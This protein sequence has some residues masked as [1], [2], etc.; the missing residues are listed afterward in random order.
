MAVLGAVYGAF[1]P[2]DGACVG[3]PFTLGTEVV[4]RFM[5]NPAEDHARIIVGHVSGSDY[6]CLTPDQDLWIESLVADL[7]DIFGVYVRPADRTMPFMLPADGTYL[8]DF[9]AAP[10]AA[11]W[12]GLLFMGQTAANAERVVRGLVAAPVVPGAP[13]VPPLPPPAGVLAG[14]GVGAAAGAMVPAGPGPGPAGGG[15]AALAA[16]AAGAWP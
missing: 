5:A 1:A 15:L 10:V 11:Q 3:G 14:L 13:V 9:V 4:V 8:H 12:D 16:A 6:V 7:V 2:L